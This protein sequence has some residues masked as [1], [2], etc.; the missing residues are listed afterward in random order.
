MP[1]MSQHALHNS[2]H[3]VKHIGCIVVCV[4]CIY[5]FVHVF[6][7][8]KLELVVNPNRLVACHTEH[9]VPMLRQALGSELC[10]CFR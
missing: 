6:G 7:S 2:Q 5:V 8:L 1:T 9:S 3:N 10:L 4:W